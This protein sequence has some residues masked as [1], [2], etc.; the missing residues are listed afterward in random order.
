SKGWHKLE[1]KIDNE[2]YHILID[3]AI[4]ASGTGDFGFT[5]VYLEVDAP[6]W[7][8]E[9]SF[10]FDDFCITRD[11]DQ[12]Y[13]DSFESKTLDPF[14]TVRQAYGTLELSS[15][16]SHLGAQSVK[17]SA[18]RGG[19]YAIAMS[20]HF[21]KVNKGTVS[22]WFYD[23]SPGAETLYAHMLLYNRIVKVYSCTALSPDGRIL[24]TGSQDEKSVNISDVRTGR[25]LSKLIG[26]SGPVS[27][28]AFSPDGRRLITGSE[29]RTVKVWDVATWR[30]VATFKGYTDT[31]SLAKF[32]PDG[33]ILATVSR[34]Y[35]VKVWQ[36]A[37]DN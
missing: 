18:R 13:C 29:D 5:D 17:L 26:H 30:E 6:S 22:V 34:D 32:S 27:C 2:G 3:N 7:R 31:V 28:I 12:N 14:W 4:A 33:K 1:I 21:D 19:D 16:Q 25:E 37:A 36:A 11:A 8:P 24:A 10:Y 9:A 20:H 15:E 35:V 23:T